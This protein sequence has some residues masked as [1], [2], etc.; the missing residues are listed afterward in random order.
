MS[1]ETGVAFAGIALLLL[2][3]FA[4][5]SILQIRRAAK[6]LTE[7]LEVLNRSLPAILKNVEEITFNVRQA[8]NTVQMQVEGLALIA[9]RIQNILAFVLDLENLLRGK[10]KLPIFQALTNLTAVK[11]GFQTFLRVYRAGK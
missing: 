5:P 8:S 9:G 7:T 3:V 1:M 4:I 6:N 10:M 11:R 2:V